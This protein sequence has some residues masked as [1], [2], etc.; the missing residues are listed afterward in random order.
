MYTYYRGTIKN[1]S[2]T[3]IFGYHMGVTLEV[4]KPQLLS[5]KDCHGYTTLQS[6][7]APMN[8][9]GACVLIPQDV[10]PLTV[11][12]MTDNYIQHPLWPSEND[13]FNGRGTNESASSTCATIDMCLYDVSGYIK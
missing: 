3:K 8:E 10:D 13:D 6:E 11:R 7:L 4:S 2:S 9:N 12:V 1:S 5:D